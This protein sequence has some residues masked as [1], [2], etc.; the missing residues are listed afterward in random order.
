MVGVD[1]DNLRSLADQAASAQASELSRTGE[2][3]QQ[4]QV[5][6]HRPAGRIR[7]FARAAADQQPGSSWAGNVPATRYANDLMRARRAHGRRGWFRRL[8]GRELKHAIDQQPAR[9]LADACRSGS[10]ARRTRAAVL[11]PAMRSASANQED[12]HYLPAR[13]CWLRWARR[14]PALILAMQGV[15]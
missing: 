13:C 2:Q 7:N 3:V 4:R 10:H 12:V 1:S 11:R 15:R 9:A 14:E 5:E 8:A 6:R